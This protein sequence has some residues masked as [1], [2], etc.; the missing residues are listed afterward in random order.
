MLR[1]RTLTVMAVVTCC[2]SN[3][4]LAIYSSRPVD[5][6][7]TRTDTGQPAAGVPVNV[8]YAS[9]L[10]LNQPKNAEGTTDTEG[11]VTLPMADFL[12]GP[13]LRAGTTKFWAPS[14]IVRAGGQL[15]YKP[16]ANPDE[17]IPVYSVRLITR[18]R[19]LAERFLGPQSE[20]RSPTALAP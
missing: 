15:A 14:E 3:G 10:T 19:S 4:C 20:S 1:H 17:P 18:R 6:V 11:R 7:V 9:I 12:G 8:S 5:I 2:F 13:T 16:T